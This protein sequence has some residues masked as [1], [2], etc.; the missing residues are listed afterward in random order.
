M[1]M[2]AP[3]TKLEK[4]GGIEKNA[5]NRLGQYIAN[6][7]SLDRW[8]ATIRNNHIRWSVNLKKH[9]KHFG[10]DSLA[11]NVMLTM[12]NLK[13]LFFIKAGKKR[14]NKFKIGHQ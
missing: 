2:M 9:R 4:E 5:L 12:V 6:I 1:E 3:T 13:T 14:L 7:A 8:L 11:K 10:P